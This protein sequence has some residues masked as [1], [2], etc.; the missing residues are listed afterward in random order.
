MKEKI[1]IKM[2]YIIGKISMVIRRWFR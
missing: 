1:T 2:I